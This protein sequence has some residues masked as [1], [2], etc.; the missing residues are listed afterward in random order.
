MLLIK[1]MEIYSKKK[2][3]T[4]EAIRTTDDKI[5]KKK[6]NSL[7]TV[8]CSGC[9]YVAWL[10]IAIGNASAFFIPTTED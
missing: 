3:I 8:A 1:G 7:C 6:C 10:I 5:Q 2:V 9:C 4:E